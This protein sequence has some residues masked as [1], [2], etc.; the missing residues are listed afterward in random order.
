MVLERSNLYY[1][2]LWDKFDHKKGPDGWHSWDQQNVD[3]EMCDWLVNEKGCKYVKVCADPGDLLLWDSVSPSPSLT[4]FT[5][6][7]TANDSL[8]RPADV[9]ERPSRRLRLL[10][11][12]GVLDR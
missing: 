2:E 11:T 10:Q 3:E 4:P 8:R 6:S 9:S 1:K 12:C 7:P 5:R